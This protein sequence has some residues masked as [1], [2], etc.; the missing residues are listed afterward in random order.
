[1]KKG[2]AA[3][4]FEQLELP[5]IEGQ[6]TLDVV[7]Q[8]GLGAVNTR[9]HDLQNLAIQVQRKPVKLNSDAQLMQALQATGKATCL[10]ILVQPFPDAVADAQNKTSAKVKGKQADLSTFKIATDST[11]GKS[12]P[13]D[14]L[15]PGQFRAVHPTAQ[16]NTRDPEDAKEELEQ[17]G[18][19]HLG[20]LEAWGD[21]RWQEVHLRV[22]LVLSAC[23]TLCRPCFVCH[24][25]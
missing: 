5:L 16:I 10:E 14:S 15:R 7:R 17:H 6:L 3:S 20:T 11:A 25:V 13:A 1:M 2:A 21:E 12:V 22:A 23:G 8:A 24:A 18:L 9:S 4:P 19:Q